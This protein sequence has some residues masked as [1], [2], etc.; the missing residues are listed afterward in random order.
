MRCFADIRPATASEADVV[1]ELVDTAFQHYVPRIG[2]RP[3]PM[4]S[5]YPVLIEQGAVWL[6]SDNSGTVRGVLVL[7]AQSDHLLLDT[8]AVHSAAQGTGLGSRLLGFAEHRARVL[9][10]P[11]IRLYTNALMTENLE[12]YPKRGYT[13]VGRRIEDGR[14][15]VFFRKPV[16][17]EFRG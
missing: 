10:L 2:I 16:P 14:D 8:V 1:T 12:Y 5:D 3:A 7:L 11:E 6:A 13:K 9:G 17:A 15:R 4:D